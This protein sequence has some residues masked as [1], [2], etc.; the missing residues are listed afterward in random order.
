MHW[1][2]QVVFT[3]MLL[4]T[5]FLAWKKYSFI[6]RNIALGRKEDLGGNSGERWRYMLL[7]A[8]G[9][10]KMFRNWL[11]AVLHLFIY[12]SF[13]I[14]NIEVLEIT[15][16]GLTGSHRAFAH[17]LGAFYPFMISLIEVLSAGALIATI[18]F[19]FRRNVVK[20]RRFTLPEMKGWPFQDAN[21]ILLFE[22]VLVTAILTMNAADYQ[23]QLRTTVNYHS[24]GTFLLS[25]Y[26]ANI[27]AGIST[28]KL[29]YLERIAWWGHITG[30]FFFLLY[31]PHSKHLHIFLSFPNSY[32]HR[33]EVKGKLPNMPVIMN[34]VKT[35]LDPSAEVQDI[36][37]PPTT[38][39]A[40]DVTDL[41][42]KHLLDAYS[43]TECGRCTAA[44]PANQTGKK[45]SPRKIMMDTR[46]RLEEVGHNRDKHGLDFNDN[47]SLL[48][49]YITAEELRACTTCN[50]C[51]EE[52]PVSI[53]PLSIIMELRRYQI[54]EQSDAPEA[55]TQMFNNL[56][57][58]QAPWQ[59]NPMERLNWKEE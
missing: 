19:L 11:P 49:D 57:N 28:Q 55:W 27:F 4:V 21:L 48:G 35:M 30:I 22:L 5:G 10:K 39:G 2:G 23:L 26:T 38:F 1:I 45:L 56:E 16:D 14:V 12:V 52:C 44:C 46:D 13:V 31:I 33:E 40:K 34:E 42:W 25:Q 20:V 8:L 51:V 54:M 41:S 3:V 37:D 24:T 7:F 32:W 50:A 43:C 53:N 6:R 59:F 17:S 58:N 29:I 9:Q 36:A 47:K 18:I 15:F